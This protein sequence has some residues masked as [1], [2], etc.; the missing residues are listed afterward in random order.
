MTSM[1]MLAHEH[2]DEEGYS[3][4]RPGERRLA[5]ALST[6][7]CRHGLLSLMVLIWLSISLS[8]QARAA[9][10]E[11]YFEVTSTGRVSGSLI[12]STDKSTIDVTYHVSNRGIGPATR[13]HITLGAAFTPVEWTVE[14]NSMLGGE[15][16]E[17]FSW[18]NGKAEWQSQ[19][20][21][22][23]AR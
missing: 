21:K 7:T 3:R 18:R 10:D 5:E 13:D 2:L 1:H 4:R 6:A 8:G 22:G 16:H 12:V 15:V 19:D 20:D 9:T 17:S 23:S 14:G 11:K